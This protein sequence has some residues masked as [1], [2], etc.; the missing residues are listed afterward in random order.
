M[1]KKLITKINHKSPSI[2]Y[3]IRKNKRK[4][5][6]VSIDGILN[7]HATLNNVIFTYT[8]LLGKPLYW[9][10]CGCLPNI[11]KGLRSKYLTI[12]DAVEFFGKKLHSKKIKNI[13][14]KFKGVGLIRKTLLK[15]LKNTKVN[16]KKIYNVT[17]VPH[18]GCRPKKYR[19]K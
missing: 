17:P 19:R 8:D 11:K 12:I 4:E 1:N 18:N 3:R 14:I 10:S 9:Y 15:G 13:Y 5:K 7:I 6:N 2:K 16:V